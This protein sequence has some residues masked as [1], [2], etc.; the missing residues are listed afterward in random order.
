M[1][2]K[3]TFFCIEYVI[4][5]EY[6]KQKQQKKLKTDEYLFFINELDEEF[7]LSA[8]I[9]ITTKLPTEFHKAQIFIPPSK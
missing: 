8:L 1:T 6:V 2:K 5:Y 9:W 7:F 4:K 3:N